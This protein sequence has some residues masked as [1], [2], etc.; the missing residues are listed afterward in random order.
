MENTIGQL[1]KDIQEL[2]E[3]ILLK[4]TLMHRLY[5]DLPSSKIHKLNER[6]RPYLELRDMY[7]EMKRKHYETNLLKRFPIG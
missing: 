2:N 1:E 6:L 4:K 5:I 7:D 3:I